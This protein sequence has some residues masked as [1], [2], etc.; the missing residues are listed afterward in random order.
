MAKK[1][2]VGN[3]KG[4]VGKTT[5][6]F[7]IGAGLAKHRDQKVL[8]IDLD[9]QCSL[10][11]I[12]MQTSGLSVAGMKPRETLN[13][14]FDLYG[15]NIKETSRLQ[16]LEGN[17]RNVYPSIK[18]IVQNIPIHGKLSFIPT[19]LDLKN[20][21]INDLADRLSAH[22]NGIISIASLLSD[23]EKENE[24]D[25]I[26]VD[27]PPSSNIII[28]GI[29]LYCDYYLIPTIG[30]EISVNGVTDYITEIESTY[31][32]FAYNDYIGGTLLKQYFG[33]KPKLIGILETIYKNRRCA[34]ESTPGNT[35]REDDNLETLRMLDVAI[36]KVLS[37]DSVLSKFPVY[38]YPNMKNIFKNLIKHLDNRSTPGNY[39]IPITVSNGEIHAEYTGITEIINQ[40]L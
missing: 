14:A 34:T 39:G 20:S 3:Y 22:E 1:I 19:A 32:K 7:E 9:P 21:R 16:I 40:I 8:L 30:D 6:V 4:S 37:E 10:T 17:I 35:F 31:L 12:C 15:E 24:F 28:Q 13:Y 36:S 27:C 26:I 23:I 33:E 25:Y 2:F 38:Q 29:F 5:T 18:N 11:N